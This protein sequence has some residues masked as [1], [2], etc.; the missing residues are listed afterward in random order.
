M[1]HRRIMI[2]RLLMF[3]ILL[4]Y[5]L[6]LAVVSYIRGPDKYK[7]DTRSIQWAAESFLCI[8]DTGLSG[9]KGNTLH[10]QNDVPGQ[11]IEF[12]TGVQLAEDIGFRI[13][14]FIDCPA[15]FAGGGIAFDL[16]N[17]E[18][19]DDWPYQVYNYALSAGPNEISYD[20]FPGENAPDAAWLR[21]FTSSKANYDIQNLRIC[22]LM[23]VEKVSARLKVALCASLLAVAV[24]GS[25]I[26]W[27]KKIE[28][29]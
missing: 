23:Q 3:E 9:V 19:G 16:Y 5:I 26:W 14:F 20:L 13:S 22:R 15:D 1:S 24:T 4:C 17:D 6:A 12:R 18:A 2:K 7:E 10:V 25:V 11:N 28:N 27:R 8:D 29:S 21:I